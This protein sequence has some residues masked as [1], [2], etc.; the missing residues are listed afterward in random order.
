MRRRF[1]RRGGGRRHHRRSFRGSFKKL[2]RA[3]R[4][5]QRSIE[6]K[7]YAKQAAPANIDNIGVLSAPLN[8]MV[9]GTTGI[10]RVGDKITCTSIHLRIILSLSTARTNFNWI[11]LALVW[12]KNIRGI[13]PT[14]ADIYSTDQYT[15]WPSL[16]YRSKNHTDQYFVLKEKHVQLDQQYTAAA[17]IQSVRPFMRII[18]WNVKLRGKFRQTVFIANTAD[19]FAAIQSGALFLI[20]IAD[21][22]ATS[23]YPTFA[24]NERLYYRDC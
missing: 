21:A 2:K 9:Q 16:A 8:A 11:K 7:Y 19:Q 5:I 10:T 14:A 17:L 4:K 12:A 24:F 15:N 22:T 6:T 20:A 18:D 23:V 13:T 3:V 1:K